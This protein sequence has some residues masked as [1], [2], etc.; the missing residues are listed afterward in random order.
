MKRYL[1]FLFAV[2]LAAYGG[3]RAVA[4]SE[5]DTSVGVMPNDSLSMVE[6][7]NKLLEKLLPDLCSRRFPTAEEMKMWHLIIEEDKDR[8]ELPVL[9]RA[10]VRAYFGNQFLGLDGDSE[11]IA[12]S[13]ALV[14]A[15]GDF[16]AIGDLD[17]YGLWPDSVYAS[18]VSYNEGVKYKVKDVAFGGLYKP[19][20]SAEGKAEGASV[21]CVFKLGK[22]PIDGISVVNGYCHTESQWKNHGRVAKMQLM[23]DG[24]PYKIFDLEDTPYTQSLFID[25]ISP[26]KSGE[27]VELTFKILR[28]Y[29]G[30][31]YNDVSISL[32]TFCSEQGADVEDEI[33]DNSEK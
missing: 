9:A 26:K 13:S 14:P 3:Q 10:L 4:Q 21:T 11:L 12:D 15:Y 25:S 5:A 24:Q 16:Y 8:N 20:C 19:W 18:S 22:R 29:P 32:L 27:P 17:W 1:F 28:V 33:L 7:E 6:E 30:A 31:K 23:V 2:V